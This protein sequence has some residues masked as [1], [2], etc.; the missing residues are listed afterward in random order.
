[1]Y[2]LHEEDA[3]KFLKAL[4]NETVDLIVTDPPYSSLDKHRAVGTTTRLHADGWFPTVRNSYF[5]EWFKEAYR[6]LV[7][8]AHLYFFCDQETAFGIPGDD[9]AVARGRAAGFTFWKALIW[10]KQKMGMGY[11]YRARHEFILFFEKGKR[12][13]NDLGIPDVLSCD[14]VRGE[15]PTQKP[16][17]L[18]GTLICQSSS[19]GDIVVD[20]FM[21]SGSTGVA[22]L[23]HH[24]HF[25]GA[26]VQRA[27]LDLAERNLSEVT[28]RIAEGL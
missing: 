19:V 4:G 6:V 1:M 27:A 28:Q 25:L 5:D 11:H 18:L 12:K 24:R 26:D 13:L 17:G 22:A 20:P 14:R 16:V 8:D 9:G 3:T 7:D 15:Y 21:G 2:Q 23:H 10:D